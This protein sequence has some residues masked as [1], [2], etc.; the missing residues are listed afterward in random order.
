MRRTL[1]VLCV[2]SSEE[3]NQVRDALLERQRCHLTSVES[4]NGLYAVSRE[5]RFDVAVLHASLSAVAMRDAG[6]VIRRRWSAACILALARRAD[7]LED[8]LY[9]EW[10]GPDLSRGALLSLLERIATP[11]ALSSRS[12]PHT[13]QRRSL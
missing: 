8:P 6:A 7:E 13:V 12:H 2:G 5:E 11:P 1:R 10:S 3:C 9:D 4:P